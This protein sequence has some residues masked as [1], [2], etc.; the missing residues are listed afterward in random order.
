MR[1]EGDERVEHVGLGRLSAGLGFAGLGI[2]LMSGLAGGNLGLIES[3]F[4]GDAA[5]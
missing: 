2:W 5:P 4:P 1:H 3:F